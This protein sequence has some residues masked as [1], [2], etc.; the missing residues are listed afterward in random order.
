MGRLIDADEFKKYIIQGAD[1]ILVSEK[2]FDLAVQMTKDF[3]KDIDEQPT[4]YDVGKVVEEL[5][6]EV[7][8][9]GYPICG[10]FDAGLCDGL[11]KAIDIV[12]KGGV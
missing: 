1:G 4:A 11:Y 2:Y 10:E 12:K 6:N 8:F 5:K 9:T 7:A 3:L